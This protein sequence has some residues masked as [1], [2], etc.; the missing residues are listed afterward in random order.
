MEKKYLINKIK[1]M[2]LFKKKVKIRVEN[3]PSL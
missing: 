2:L 1:K 3:E